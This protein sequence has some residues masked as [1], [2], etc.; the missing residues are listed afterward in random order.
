MSELLDRAKIGE[1]LEELSSE[2]ARRDIEGHIYLV[3]GAALV[4][5]YQSRESTHD[6]DAQFGPAQEI[7]DA[8]RAVGARNGLPVDWL[9]DAAKGFLPARPDPNPLV[10]FSSSSLQVEI[11]SPEYLLAMKLFASRPESDIDDIIFLYEHLGFT[12]VDEGL[13]LVESFY[14][15]R[16]IEVRVQYFLRDI[17]ESL[18]PTPKSGERLAGS[19]SVSDAETGDPSSSGSVRCS[20]C[21]RLLRS[22]ASVAR[23]MGP[24]CVRKR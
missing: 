14:G 12:T 15:S 19:A 5:R 18:N 11:A 16:P 10:G 6:L 22:A 17:V 13:D 23:G 3:G 2:L 9:N 7:R 1:L 20:R 24:G 8:A 21:H 4:Y